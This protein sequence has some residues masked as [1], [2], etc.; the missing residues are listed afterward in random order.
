MN[1]RTKGFTLI[2]LLVVIAIIAVLIG[3]LLPAVQKVR[4][5]AAR[6]KCQN[7]LKQLGLALHNFHGANGAFPLGAE[8]TAGGYWS[9]FILPYVEQSAGFAAATFSEGSGN[10]QWAEPWPGLS[11]AS[12]GSTDPSSRNIALEETVFSLFRCP[13]ANI[14][15]HIL[16]VSG[17]EGGGWVVQKRVPSTYLGCASGTATNDF[18]PSPAEGGVGG[19]SS[20]PYGKPLW[21]EN[22]I[23][24]SRETRPTVADGGMAHIR[25]SDVIDGSSNT[26][27]LGEAVPYLDDPDFQMLHPPPENYG[28]GGRKDHWAFG[29]DDC[30]NYEGCDW[31]EAMGSTGVPIN[32]GGGAPL[33]RSDPLYDAWEVGFGSRHSGGANFCFADGSVRF[34]SD[35]IKQTTFRALGT[36]AGG[37]VVPND[38]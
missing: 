29:G 8:R 33:D 22:G 3:L 1:R 38:Y 10:A 31:S 13:S 15:D 6:A 21:K 14:P 24:I 16:D 32:I 4:D 28:H 30:D 17:Y 11:N 7:N 2:E 37:E 5:A 9:A 20:S 18:R 23:F 35:S 25:V 26:I 12:L 27:A 36:R 19:P 34:I